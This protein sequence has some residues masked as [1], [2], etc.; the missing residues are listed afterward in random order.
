MD[1]CTHSKEDKRPKKKRE[2]KVPELCGLNVGFGN[3]ML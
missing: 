1:T 3:N 2:R